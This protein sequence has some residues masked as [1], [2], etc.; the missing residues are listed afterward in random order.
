MHQSEPI[1]E[2]TMHQSSFNINRRAPDNHAMSVIHLVSS[3]DRPISRRPGDDGGGVGDGCSRPVI[4]TMTHRYRTE[5]ERENSSA[6]QQVTAWFDPQFQFTHT[7]TSTHG[8]VRSSGETD[9]Q[10]GAR[11]CSTSAG[12][13]PPLLQG[14]SPR[15]AEYKAAASGKQTRTMQPVDTLRAH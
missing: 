11:P 7:H 12:G 13:S 14:G 6:V 8:P 2:R 15:V 4:S 1:N 3:A 5:R 9:T 10:V